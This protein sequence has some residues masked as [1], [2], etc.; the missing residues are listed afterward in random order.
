M[1]TGRS[2]PHLLQQGQAHFMRGEYDEAASCYQGAIDL[3]P[4]SFAA[5]H[6]LALAHYM[7]G[8][9]DEA[10][11]Q[12]EQAS[13]LAPGNAEP[14]MMIGL[15]LYRL[16]R[17]EDSAASA[18]RAIGL[19]PASAEA[20]NNLAAACIGLGRF[21]EAADCAR[22]AIGIK[23]DYPEAYNNL[24]T[25]C[26]QLG[27][28][29]DA[30]KYCR[31]ALELRP[32]SV[33][34]QITLGVAHY[35]LGHRDEALIAFRRAITLQPDS[36]EAYVN[37]ATLALHQ[38]APDEAVAHCQKVIGLRPGHATAHYTLGLALFRQGQPAQAMACFERSLALNPDSPD[39]QSARAY[40]MLY[41]PETTPLEILNAHREFAARREAS[42]K[43][44][45]PRHTNARD[46]D[47]R[48][49]VG[50]V[51][52]DFRRHSVASFIEPVIEGHDRSRFQVHCYY[53]TTE[54]DAVTGR[55]KSAA[56]HWTDCPHLSDEQLAGRI[57]D[58]GIDILVDLAGHTRDGRLPAFARKP[59]PLQVTYLG[60]PA[61]TGLDAMDYRLCTL[62]TDPPGQEAWHSETLYRLPRTLW[63]YRPPGPRPERAATAAGAGSITFGS[64]NNIAKVSIASFDAWA[65]ILRALP[66]ARLIMTSV[67]Q[68]SAHESIVRLLTARGISPQRMVMHDKLGDSDFERLLAEI[69]IALDPFPYTGTTTTCETLW[70]GIPVVTLAGETSVARSGL[71]LLTSVGL[72]EL[73][74][75]N[76]A[77]YVR[78]ATDLARDTDRLDRLRREIPTRFDASPLRDEAAFTRDLEA[79]Y[80]DMW[81]RW[82][83]QESHT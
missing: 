1:M 10:I 22:R 35:K 55:L 14:H 27:R 16:G 78:I 63:C 62:A 70:M 32:G 77:D 21:D 38:G 23:P 60:Y 25:A 33:A 3:D 74:A 49:R 19:N 20:H 45:W 9:L 68:G 75:R 83:A 67:P 51:S 52:P 66:A 48:L 42:L 40:S 59:A 31:E 2:V 7:S 29:E 73:I 53:S 18:R 12:F 6:N 41:L 30:L 13:R 69:D 44:C 54:S 34:A 80:R 28:P 61:T 50:Y 72:G 5:R 57:R 47:R 82:C 71:A 43:P 39:A 56:D 81:R 76:A 15:S 24:A 8:R 64:F 37:L 79:A 17:L 46:P 4:H 65:E 26:L 58:D 36:V 11:A